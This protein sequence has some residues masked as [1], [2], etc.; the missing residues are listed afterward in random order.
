M[1]SPA[2]YFGYFDLAAIKIKRFET[3]L[4]GVIT[5]TVLDWTAPLK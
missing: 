5:V 3:K 2:S 4:M 1:R